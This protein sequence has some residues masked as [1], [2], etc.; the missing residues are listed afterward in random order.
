MSTDNIKTKLKK[1]LLAHTPPEEECHVLYL[2]A[3]IRKWLDQNPRV[4]YPALRLY[5]NWCVHTAHEHSNSF[6]TK[7]AKTVLSDIQY[8][9][10]NSIAIKSAALEEF[11]S[12]QELRNTLKE[13]LTNIFLPAA[14][15]DAKNWPHFQQLLVGIVSEQPII[16]PCKGIL[17]F[18]YNED[19]TR[20]VEYE[21]QPRK[22]E[23][24]S[25]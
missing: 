9:K 3:E 22:N 16:D 20:V 7:T 21:I 6:L 14:I 17:G 11:F 1:H 18:Y 23:S 8:C 24:F 12:M 19:G 25:F 5:C 2:M 4:K 13:F 15:T 10:I